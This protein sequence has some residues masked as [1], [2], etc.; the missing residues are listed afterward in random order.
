MPLFFGSCECSTWSIVGRPTI[1]K[2]LREVQ[3]LLGSQRFCPS[4]QSEHWS[5]ENGDDRLGMSFKVGRSAFLILLCMWLSFV[6]FSFPSL[7]SPV[8]VCVCVCVC[9]CGYTSVCL[10][11]DACLSPVLHHDWHWQRSGTAHWDFR[12]PIGGG[13]W[14]LG[15][16]DQ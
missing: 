15:V 8:F 3:S 13:F 6:F 14:W 9:L 4:K 11:M 10:D 5:V 16:R 7:H 2:K 12:F 1:F